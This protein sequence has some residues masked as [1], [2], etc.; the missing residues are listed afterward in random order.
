MLCRKSPSVFME[1]TAHLKQESNRT[2]RNINLG[3]PLGL[4]LNSPSLRIR[5]PSESERTA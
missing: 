2:P 4:A 5:F 3:K 1:E